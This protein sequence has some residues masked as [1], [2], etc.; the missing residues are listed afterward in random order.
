MRKNNTITVSFFISRVMDDPAHKWEIT[1]GKDTVSR[2]KN[3]GNDM[4]DFRLLAH[5]PKVV[6]VVVL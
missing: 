2:T 3:L 1:L 5:L 4:G 6:F